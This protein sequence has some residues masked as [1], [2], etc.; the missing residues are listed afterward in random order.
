MAANPSVPL[1]DEQPANPFYCPDYPAVLFVSALR[2][3]LCSDAGSPG[4]ASASRRRRG[5]EPQSFARNLD[6]ALF[7]EEIEPSY[8][9][10]W[11]QYSS[12]STSPADRDNCRALVK[13]KRSSDTFSDIKR[14]AKY[15]KS[16]QSVHESSFEVD[17]NAHRLNYFPLNTGQSPFH[18]EEY[19]WRNRSNWALSKGNP[20]IRELTLRVLALEGEHHPS[21]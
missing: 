21:N 14:V 6:R 17:I 20:T 12:R 4:K 5:D 10:V 13:R 7:P 8:I 9:S 11:A 1:V 16:Y 3:R 15:A 2:R 19:T 18:C